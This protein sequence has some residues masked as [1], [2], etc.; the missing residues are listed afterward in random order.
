V[1]TR[2]K[3]CRPAAPA[4]GIAGSLPA[5][6]LV[7]T[8]A[9][10]SL[11]FA[12]ALV[13]AARAQSSHSMRFRPVPAESASSRENAAL[14][15]AQSESDADADTAAWSTTPTVPPPPAVPTPPEP[16]ETPAPATRS[17]SGDIV[18]FGSDVTVHTNQ[19]VEGDVVSF[20]GSVE[21]RGHVTGNVSAMG[22]D[23]TLARTAV[24]DGDVVCIGGTLREEPGS[25]VRGQRVTA[26]HTPGAKVFLP[27]L[28]V[29]GTG[30]Q[31]V[32]HAIGLLI[33]L[34][35]AWLFVKIAPGRT[36]NALDLIER[37]AGH[38]FVIGL[39]VWALIIPSVIA[40]A[41]V[42]AV[43]CITIIGIPLAMAV[44]LGY[45]AFFVLA[46]L[47]GSVVGYGVLGH[48][49]YPRFKGGQATL[50]QSVLWGGIALHALRIA[51]DLFKVVPVFGFVGGLLTFV[52]FVLLV[53]LGTLGAGALVRGEYQRRSL[54]TWWQRM[55]PSSGVPRNDSPPAPP[56][57]PPAGGAEVIS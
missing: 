55:R 53:T 7:A 8:A 39:L 13:P 25:V 28:A 35:I 17:T 32:A 21:V 43:L 42:I 31:M 33:M 9:A 50:L 30:F 14:E 48:R 3:T 38:A 40:L 4:V 23:L 6:A 16:G 56:P 26:P 52:Y 46:T 47:W 37:E 11:A 19:K 2:T 20:G 41:L 34:G 29:V 18:R 22:G 10:L 12:L 27:M 5:G 1:R 45:A 49:L 15:R 57:P 24:V 44:A 54:Q 51:G 36:Q